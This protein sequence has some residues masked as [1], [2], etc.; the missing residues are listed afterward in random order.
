MYS[1]VLATLLTAGGAAPDHWFGH[2]FGCHGCHGCY[3]SCHGCY[4]CSGCYGGCYGCSGCYGGCYGCS[5]CY[6]G[7]CY[8]GGCYG[9]GC[10]GCS[11]CYG[12]GYGGCYGC[13]GASCY[14]CGGCYG[15]TGYYGCNGC[16]GYS[17]APVA[18]IITTPAKKEGATEE[19]KDK[20]NG[21]QESRLKA[22]ATVV[23]KAPADA[24]LTVNGQPTAM[25]GSEQT[26]ATPDLEVGRTYAYLFQVEST[27]DGKTVSRTRR[28]IIQAGQR[29]E[30]DLNEATTDTARIT[31]K[32]PA[33]A[34]LTVN[35][36]AVTAPEGARTFETPK[37]EAGRSYY[38]T[39]RAEMVRN[40]KT[41]TEDKRVVVEAG[42]AVTVEF[43]EPPAVRTASR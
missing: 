31:V 14:G 37:L 9:G 20:P 10:Y 11:G 36:V 24:R 13:Y 5:G 29:A 41:H 3:G 28:L 27:Q 12:G 35:G 32:L 15:C 26:F 38:Y 18:P 1:V 30:V 19:K 33:D 40:G 25:K 6:G 4:G 43:T 16:Y 42:R 34:R 2:S 39:L 8:G 22:P 7:G 23:V 17:V 21:T